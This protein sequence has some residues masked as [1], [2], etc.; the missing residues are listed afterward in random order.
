VLGGASHIVLDLVGD[1]NEAFEYTL[2]VVGGLITLW[3]VLEIGRRR[4]LLAW[5]GPAPRVDR[6]PRLFWGVSAPL[7]VLGFIV[8]P[9]LP[10]AFLQHTTGARLIAVV[11]LALLAGAVAVASRNRA[12]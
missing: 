1:P 9:F 4:L 2:H 11:A 10:A 12:G 5:H 8:V 3:V 6:Q 7:G